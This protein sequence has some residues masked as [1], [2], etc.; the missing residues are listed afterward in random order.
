[1]PESLTIMLVDD[2]AL[3]RQALKR[4]LEG[5]GYRVVDYASG[6]EATAYV[7]QNLGSVSYAFIDHVLQA[8]LRRERLGWH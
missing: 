4:R 8:G 2:N 6:E 1:M 7:S 3:L 5:H